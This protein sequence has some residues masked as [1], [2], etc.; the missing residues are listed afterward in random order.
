MEVSSQAR[1]CDFNF[2][3]AHNAAW[4]LEAVLYG[5]TVPHHGPARVSPI[6]A[7]LTA[8]SDFD[9]L[10]AAF[11]SEL[12]RELDLVF[13]R[14]DIYFEAYA[15]YRPAFLISTMVYDCL[16]RGR[17]LNDGGARYADFCGSVVGIPDV[18]DSLLALKRALFDEGFCQASEMLEAL[19]ADFTGHEAL[20]ARLSAL[21]KYGQDD[22]DADAMCNRV[23]GVY[24]DA[25]E[26]HRTP[27]GGKVRPLVLG[28]VWVA[29]F[30]A[31]TGALPDGR[32]AGQPLAHGLA[33][34]GGAA[35]HGLSAA[36]NS[37]T[38]L[39]LYRVPG[40]ASM[41][42]DLDTSWA[43]P[44]VVEATLSAFIRRGGHI[45]QGNTSDFERLEDA[46]VHPERHRDLMVRV[47][48]F[49]ARFVNLSPVI[50][51]EIVARRR[52]AG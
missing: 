31:I 37:A 42:F 33:P 39:D 8:Y 50:Q 1:N 48:G 46:L 24:C 2:T 11:E 35:I 21:P 15:R 29:E 27:H 26:A 17:G 44:D 19:R 38:S 18:A 41:V 12:R 43:T 52:Y 3:Y 40:G 14:L 45:F 22:P 9:G 28:F 7:D 36:L 32:K 16:E 30:G 23:L 4:T 51:Q 6:E 10:F 5:G 25:C 13:R 34:Q 49:S 20:R 47:G